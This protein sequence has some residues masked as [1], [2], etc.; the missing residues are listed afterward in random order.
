[1]KSQDVANKKLEGESL[2]LSALIYSSVLIDRE[3]SAGWRTVREMS[4][5]KHRSYSKKYRGEWR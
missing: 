4:K 5:V 1:M 2:G 3:S